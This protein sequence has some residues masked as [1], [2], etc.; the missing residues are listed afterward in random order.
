MSVK[1]QYIRLIARN[2]NEKLGDAD[3]HSR[4]PWKDAR[5]LHPEFLHV[6]W[7]VS[8][9]EAGRGSDGRR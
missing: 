8:G 5:L 6:D 2:F 9:I 4:W 7:S 1:I 3:G